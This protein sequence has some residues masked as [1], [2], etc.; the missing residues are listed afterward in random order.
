RIFQKFGKIERYGKDY[1]V[2]IEGPGLGLY[3]AKQIIEMHKGE[4]KVESEGLNKG[5]TFII[6]LPIK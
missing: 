1:D 2:D 5:A 3:L 4:I 6:E